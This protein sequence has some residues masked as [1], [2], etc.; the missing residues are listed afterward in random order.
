MC[1]DCPALGSLSHLSFYCMV[2][3]CLKKQHKQLVGLPNKE[4]AG[5]GDVSVSADCYWFCFCEEER[6]GCRQVWKKATRT[7]K[8]TVMKLLVTIPIL[9]LGLGSAMSAKKGSEAGKLTTICHVT[10]FSFN[11]FTWH[12]KYWWLPP[13]WAKEVLP[14][15]NVWNRG[16]VCF[17]KP[18][19]Q[20]L[21]Q[22]ILSVTYRTSESNAV[23]RLL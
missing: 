21:C 7:K 3:S 6:R 16:N 17:R 20:G 19:N 2:Y 10:F 12:W 8:A 23:P 9:L 14:P 13:G 15:Y 11:N 18:H 1:P 22:L 4:K 5:K